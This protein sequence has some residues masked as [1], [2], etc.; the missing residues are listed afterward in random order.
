MDTLREKLPQNISG[1]KRTL[2]IALT[3]SIHLKRKHNVIFD[4]IAHNKTF[5]LRYRIAYFITHA[6][7]ALTFTR[8]A[9]TISQRS[10]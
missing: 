9:H 6:T 4:I 8:I 1:R 7:K 10:K 3:I 2:K 5:L